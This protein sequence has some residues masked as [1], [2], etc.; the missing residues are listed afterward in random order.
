MWKHVIRYKI[1]SKGAENCILL[2]LDETIMR[3]PESRVII[4]V[5]E[6]KK[7][8]CIKNIIINNNIWEMFNTN[9]LKLQKIIIAVNV[10]IVIRFK[11]I[12]TSIIIKAK[13]ELFVFT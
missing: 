13:C 11:F 10:I 7:I 8:K 9:L 5:I 3:T 1:N 12:F 4:V 2:L 6:L